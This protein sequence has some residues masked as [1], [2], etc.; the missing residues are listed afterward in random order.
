M[1]LTIYLWYIYIYS[2]LENANYSK[3]SLPKCAEQN[4]WCIDMYSLG[5]TLK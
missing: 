1:L 5:L 3:F 4:D 2:S